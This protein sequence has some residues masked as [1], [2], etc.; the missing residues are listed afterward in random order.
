MLSC[1]LLK[2]AHT[3]YTLMIVTDLCCLP[4]IFASV[5][6]PIPVLSTFDVVL[7]DHGLLMMIA[8]PPGRYADEEC[9]TSNF[10]DEHW[11]CVRGFN[12][13]RARNLVACPSQFRLV[14][15]RHNISV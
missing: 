12:D 9:G 14:S 4:I 6:R 8:V 13:F 7:Q 1:R 15:M 11:K 10:M 2:S 3:R 5:H